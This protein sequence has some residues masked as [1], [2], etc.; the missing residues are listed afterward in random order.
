MRSRNPNTF[1]N[2]PLDR[3]GHVRAKP[4]ELASLRRAPSASL[5][6]VRDGRPFVAA[7]KGGEPAKLA[8]LNPA[9]LD[10]HAEGATEIFLG[11]DDKGPVFAADVSALRDP[12]DG[13][14]LHGLGEFQELRG[15]LPFLSGGDAAIV[16]QAKSLLDW[17]ARH[18][19]CAKCGAPTRLTQGGYRR[20]CGACKAEH[21]PRT[22]P[23]AIMLA[24]C[25][26]EV[27]LGRGPQWPPKR[28]S[29][30]AGFLEPGETIEEGVAREIFE[31][32]GVRTAS[33]RYL[34]SQ[35]WPFP[36]SLM[37]GCVAEVES[38]T[39]RLDPA[40]LADARWFAREELPALLGGTHADGC[41][42]PPPFAIAH[43]LI[44][45]WMAG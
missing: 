7:R 27:L 2:S 10:A 16:G 43:Q 3:A 12:E 33:V 29:A 34:F 35:P 6:L 24:A 44:R 17:H 37:I 36:S 20:D 15:L 5:L 32:A 41:A 40:E 23:V 13:G 26:G 25:G 31:E 39:L 45:A 28:Y 42:G 19:F 30:L 21:F 11:L 14:P 4:E 1:A 9:F 8:W 22:D 18:G 38:K